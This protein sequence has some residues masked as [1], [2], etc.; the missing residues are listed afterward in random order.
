VKG[1]KRPVVESQEGKTPALG[2]HQ[3][4]AL[5][6]APD[7][8]SVKGKRDRQFW[9]PCSTTRYA[10]IVSGLGLRRSTARHKD[11]AACR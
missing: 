5:L 9:P 7:D 8:V 2:D 4:R 3:A 6:V 1:V 10:G 11:I